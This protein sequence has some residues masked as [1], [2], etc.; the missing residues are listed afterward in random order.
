MALARRQH[1]RHNHRAGVHG[2]TLERIV[3]ILAMR[4]RAIDE[5]SAGS[6]EAARMA[7][8]GARPL[9]VAAG[10]RAARYSPRCARLRRDRPRRSAA[11][12]TFAAQAAASDPHV[13]RSRA[14]QAARQ[15]RSW[16]IGRSQDHRDHGVVDSRRAPPNFRLLASATIPNVRTSISRPSTAMAA[17]S[18]LSLRS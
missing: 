5:G 2:A 9:I 8:G 15:R 1:R 13:T 18:P 10:K 3:K 12:R 11:L 16:A 4:C 17:R 7:N 14:R 6:A